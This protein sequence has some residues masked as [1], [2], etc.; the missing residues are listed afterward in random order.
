MRNSFVCFCKWKGFNFKIALQDKSAILFGGVLLGA[1]WITYF[2][3]LKLSNEPLECCLC[4]PTLP[5]LPFYNRLYLK[6]KILKSH[7]ILV[8]IYFL[9]PDFNVENNHFK[10]IC[11]RMFSAFCYSFR[12]IIMKSKVNGYNGSVLMANQLFVIAILLCP[13]YLILDGTNTTNYLAT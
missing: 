11:F 8:E 10:A 1:H 2:Y 13:L 7:L 5:K 3:A 9:V 6:T 4:L 12:N